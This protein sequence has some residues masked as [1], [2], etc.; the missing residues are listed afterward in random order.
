M[1]LNTIERIGIINILPRTGNYITL[2]LCESIK[3]KVNLTESEKIEIE[4]VE[5]NGNAMWNQKGQEK[6]PIE[7]SDTEIIIIKSELNKL[8]QTSSLPVELITLYEIF[9][10]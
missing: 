4:Y 1:E 3:S 10:K 7:L 2:K 5:T 6:K 9:S 8:D